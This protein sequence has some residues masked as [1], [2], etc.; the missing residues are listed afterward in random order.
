MKCNIN[1]NH[2]IM[3]YDFCATIHMTSEEY[4]LLNRAYQ[5]FR[6]EEQNDYLVFL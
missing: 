2:N 5:E 6:E 1:F 3:D 4:E